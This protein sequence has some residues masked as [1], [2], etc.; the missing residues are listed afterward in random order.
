L[1]DGA[2]EREAILSAGS[3]F[4][5]GGKWPV[6]AAAVAAAAAVVDDETVFC[7]TSRSSH[8][9]VIRPSLFLIRKKKDGKKPHDD[10]KPMVENFLD[11]IRTG[12]TGKVE[13]IMRTETQDIG[14]YRPPS[15]DHVKRILFSPIIHRVV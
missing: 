2:P 13:R 14:H 8:A 10:D 6:A 5:G 7:H 12:R 1:S 15:V 4:G 3:A 11:L 9:V